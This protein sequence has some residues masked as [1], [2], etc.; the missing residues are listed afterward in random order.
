MELAEDTSVDGMTPRMTRTWKSPSTPLLV[1]PRRTRCSWT[2]PSRVPHCT[3]WWILAPCTRSS[4]ATPLTAR[5]KAAPRP[6]LTMGV[7][8]GDY[9]PSNGVCNRVEVTIG[10]EGFSINMFIMPLRASVGLSLAPVPRPIFVMCTGAGAQLFAPPLHGAPRPSTTPLS[11]VQRPLRRPH[12][13]A[14][15]PRLLPSHPPPPR[16]SAH[17]G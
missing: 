8:N 10:S 6:G 15:R 12:L 16:H 11:R 17:R 2:P 3:P 13:A 7:A 14:A 5:P 1:S 4:P 9:V